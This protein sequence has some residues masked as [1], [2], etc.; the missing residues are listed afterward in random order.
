M[1]CGTSGYLTRALGIDNR[2]DVDYQSLSLEAGDFFLLTT[3]GVHDYL[4]QDQIAARLEKGD[5]NPEK[6]AQTLCQEALNSNS[7]DNAMSLI[8][9]VTELPMKSAIDIHKKTLDCAIP[10]ALK[11]NNTID[12][13]K[14]VNILNESSRSYVYEVIEKGTGDRLWNGYYSLDNF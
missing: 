4:P 3:D 10:S 6:T 7:Q 11:V 5:H 2:L 8:V 14:V 1:S 12:G 13:F 9:S